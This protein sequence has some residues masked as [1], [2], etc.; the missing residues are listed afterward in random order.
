MHVLR[1]AAGKNIDAQLDDFGVLVEQGR[2]NGDVAAAVQTTTGRRLLVVVDEAG[3]NGGQ[4]AH[5]LASNIIADFDSA[6]GAAVPLQTWLLAKFSAVSSEGEGFQTVLAI[7]AECDEGV[8]AMTVGDGR[9]LIQ[10]GDQTHVSMDLV[11]SVH[12]GFPD[13]DDFFA[14]M[15]DSFRLTEADDA[16]ETLRQIWAQ[17][18]D[19]ERAELRKMTHRSNL[20]S[21]VVIKNEDLGHHPNVYRDLPETSLH[22]PDDVP[23][24]EPQDPELVEDFDDPADT[25]D[26]VTQD[27]PVEASKPLRP[28]HKWAV[29]SAQPGDTITA[30]AMTDGATERVFMCE[31][32]QLLQT[33]D[34]AA[35]LDLI[36]S[37][38]D[39]AERQWHTQGAPDTVVN[40]RTSTT[41]D[42]AVAGATWTHKTSNL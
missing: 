39:S 29:I 38:G 19:W 13:I 7:V 6:P 15:T 5:D 25:L 14:R 17:L 34:L 26:H 35:A 18:S 16:K 8:A 28:T 36:R 20:P 1:N 33:E 31:L 11:E 24:P 22:W 30:L 23:R 9:V 42:C 10:A 2:A 4:F 3:R 27:H 12:D 40:F 37:R 41:D 21:T 32:L